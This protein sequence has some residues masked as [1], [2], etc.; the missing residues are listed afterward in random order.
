MPRDLL[1]CAAGLELAKNPDKLSQNFEFLLK[2]MDALYQVKVCKADTDLLIDQLH[3]CFHTLGQE[4][5]KDFKVKDFEKRLDEIGHKWDDIKKDQPQVKTDVEPIQQSEGERIKQEIDAYG[6][7]V[8]QYKIQFKHRS[9][10][11]YATGYAAAYPELDRVAAEL[12]GLKTELLHFRE[13]A[14]VFE[15]PQLIETINGHIRELLEDLVMAK[16]VWDTVMLCELQFKDWRSTLWADIK[17]DIMEEGAKA[18]VKDVKALPKRIR[19]EDCYKGLDNAVKNFLVSVPLV[20]DLRSPAMRQRHW[21]QLMEL[22]KKD[23]DVYNKDFRLD[24]LLNLELHKFEEEVGEIVDRAQ[25]EEKMEQALGKLE[26]T[27]KRLEFQFIPHKGTAVSTIKMAEE[28]FEALEDNQVLVQ[29]MMANRYMNT[30]RDAIIGWN[31]KLMNV[32][33]VNQIMT[34]IQRTWAYLESLFIHSEEVKKELPEAATR[35]SN[36][37]TEVKKVLGE[38]REKKNCVECCNADGLM[39]FLEKQQSEL[40]I[41]EKALAD[42]MESKRRAFPRFYFVSTADLLDILSNGNSPTKVMIHMSKCF[43]AIDRL[44]LDNDTP[45]PGV[46]PKGLGMVSCV[47][48]EYVEW[49]KPLPLEN[50]VE[51]YLNDII[52]KMRDELRWVLKDSVED[53]PKKARDKWIF[54]WPSQVILVVNQIF[55]CQEVEQA[56]K[57]MARGDKGAMQKYN[58]FQVK[59]LTKLIEVTRC[60]PVLLGGSMC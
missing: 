52:N 31:K 17:T 15:F 9:F 53:Y 20:A 45:A 11:K 51:Q 34:E 42:Y 13:L 3:E 4:K 12:E 60:A 5:M 59:Q 43:Q 35:F 47:G 29:G 6:H 26:E 38:F 48:S 24:D 41:C 23:F 28:D 25:K 32:A 7:K 50:K 19:D 57:D 22:T 10:F 21:Q 55:W 33:D 37:D 54:D 16:D 40:E 18:F 58:D 49:R 46:R 39:K 2:T 36:I 30:F 44:K 56:F 14:N 8:R 1:C 27:W